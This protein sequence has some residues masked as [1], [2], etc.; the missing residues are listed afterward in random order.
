M[1]KLKLL[2]LFSGI[3]G[4]SYGL[5]STKGFETIA[6]CEKDKFCQK[7]LKKHWND[8][9]IYEDVRNIK[10][11]EIKADVITGGF[12]CQP[13]SVAGKQRGTD[14]DRYLWD[15]TLRVIA[16]T[17]PKWFVGENVEGIVNIQEGKVLQ[18]I[19]KDLETESFK[20]QCLIIPASG[21]GA[22]HQRKRVWI[23]AYSNSGL[24]GRRRTI[25][26]SGEN[27]VRRIYSSKEEQ[28]KDDIRSKAIGCDA[29]SGKT[30]TNTNSSRQ[31]EF[32]ISK[33][34]NRK[35]NGSRQYVEEQNYKSWWQTQSELCGVPD[36]I[37]YGLDKD[38]ANRIKSLGNSIVP[39]IAKE[40]G[41]AILEAENEQSN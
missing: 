16:E 25:E 14:D 38:R 21:Y 17:K 11:S 24:R 35:I 29:V 22:W 9:K 5:E 39:E 2:D 23:I 12:P 10:G 8:I 41:L 4:F 7:V 40:I 3:G 37:S 30:N 15:E 13:F 6:F 26:Q 19:Q 1:N 27:E 31:Q 33:K 18:Q 20:V 28:A 32:N 36:G 34:S